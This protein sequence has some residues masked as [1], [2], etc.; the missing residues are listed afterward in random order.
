MKRHTRDTIIA[1]INKK[2]RN[3]EANNAVVMLMWQ[4]LILGDP[5]FWK[6]LFET[7]CTGKNTQI[8]AP[9]E[10]DNDPFDR[11]GKK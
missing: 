10:P 2:I 5:D 8:V 6:P 9:P 3:N 7:W 1:E 11:G 4:R